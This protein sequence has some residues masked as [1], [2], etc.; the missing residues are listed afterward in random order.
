MA[1]SLY[2]GTNEFSG[3]DCQPRGLAFEGPGVVGSKTQ[4][5]NLE[6]DLIFPW[7]Q[8]KQKTTAL[9]DSTDQKW[10]M[11]THQCLL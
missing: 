7:G 8:I 4:I 5:S 2:G 3:N 1:V 6:P 10:P 9:T 11:M